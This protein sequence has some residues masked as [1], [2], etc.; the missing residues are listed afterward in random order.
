M[1]TTDQCEFT[2]YHC[3]RCHKRT[4]P[5]ALSEGVRVRAT[6]TRFPRLRAAVTQA[7]TAIFWAPS[8]LDTG[9]SVVPAAAV[10]RPAWAPL[11]PVLPANEG[12][13][14]LLFACV[15]IDVSVDRRVFVFQMII[16]YHG[17]ITGLVPLNIRK[18][19]SINSQFLIISHSNK[20][21]NNRLTLINWL[22]GS[23]LFR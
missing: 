2:G 19:D 18:A 13:L 20:Q 15:M 1:V 8:L 7:R 4:C 14:I 5:T 11:S 21:K 12:F 16:H 6:R 17:C 23:L 3:K 22:N 10:L 9:Y